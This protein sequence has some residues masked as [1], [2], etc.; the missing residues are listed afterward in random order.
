MSLVFKQ[1]YNGESV[2]TNN[3]LVFKLLNTNGGSGGGSA[4]TYS[5]QTLTTLLPKKSYRTPAATIGT[6]IYIINLFYQGTTYKGIYIF[7]TISETITT[8]NITEIL[9]T[10]MSAVSV[11]NDIYTFAGDESPY[12]YKFD[13][14]SQTV[15][16]I[17]SV[18]NIYGDTN[19]E[20]AS[21]VSIGSNIYAFGGARTSTRNYNIICKIDTLTN[22]YTKLTSTL[23]IK[24]SESGYAGIGTDI[25][26][27]GGWGDSN[28]RLAEIF[29]FDSVTETITTLS[30][31]LP[32]PRNGQRA[33]T[34]GTDI[35]IFGGYDGTKGTEILKFDTKTENITIL[36]LVLPANV[37]N[38][39]VANVGKDAYIFGV[40]NNNS[41]VKFTKG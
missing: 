2:K 16:V 32:T 20:F 29:K 40:E 31:T 34:M 35:Y 1:L 38:I 30:T 13:S 25:Y 21:S 3:G 15:S 5:L 9:S 14:I 10:Y 24:C 11:G 37:V 7:D 36:E 33:V 6:N 8:L 28:V 17:G 27:F 41:I 23:P 18:K 4:E 39:P 12:I 19:V 26:I 22:S